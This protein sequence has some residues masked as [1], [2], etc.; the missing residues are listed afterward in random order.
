[1][2]TASKTAQP[3][4][5]GKPKSTPKSARS[6]R[7]PLRPPAKRVAKKE[8]EKSAQKAAAVPKSQKLWLVAGA[9]A[10]ALVE[11]PRRAARRFEPVELDPQRVVRFPE[12]VLPV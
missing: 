12:D 4:R 11:W 8:T 7:K 2:A 5:R 6:P 9:C 3:S 1:M 10:R